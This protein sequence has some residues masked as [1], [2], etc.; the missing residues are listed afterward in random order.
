MERKVK[1]VTSAVRIHPSGDRCLIVEFGRRIAPDINYAVRSLAATLRQH[2]LP[3]VTDVVPAFA[4]VAIYYRPEAIAGLRADA[5]PHELLCEQ[6][7]AIVARGIA[8]PQGD[9]RVVDIPV[10][11]EGEFA[12]DLAEVAALCKLTRDQ[13]IERHGASPHVV[14]MLGFAPGFAYIGGL[15]KRLVVPRR[16]TPRTR[17]P[18]GSVAIADELSAIYPLQTPGGWN[19]IG[20][21][22]LKLFDPNASPPCLLQ[23]GDEVRFIAISLQEFQRML[24]TQS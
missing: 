9:A 10:C 6:V 17:I 5:S 13:I 16:A 3:G 4:T 1:A 15:D 14:Y 21:T 24:A 23:P 2:P 8:P 20:R 7:Q 12:P 18:T 19:V 22:P 11:Y